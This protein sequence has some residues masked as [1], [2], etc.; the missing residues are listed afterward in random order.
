MMTGEKTK[1]DV[2]KPE[3]DHPIWKTQSASPLTISKGNGMLSLDFRSF[4]R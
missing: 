3:G 2:N 4:C 1:V